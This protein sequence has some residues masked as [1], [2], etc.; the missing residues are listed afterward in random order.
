MTADQSSETVELVVMA[1][2]K[3]SSQPNYEVRRR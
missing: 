3:F 2:D 1:V